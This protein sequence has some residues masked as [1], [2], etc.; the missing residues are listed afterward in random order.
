M[1]HGQAEMLGSID[2]QRSLTEHGKQEAY[3]MAQWLQQKQPSLSHVFVSPF[4]RAQQTA[5]VVLSE[6]KSTPNCQ[7]V[8]FITPEGSAKAFHDF[9]DGVCEVE[10]ISSLLVVSHMPLVSFLIEELTTEQQ[11]PI[12]QTAAIAQIDYDLKAMK[13]QL[14]NL[15]SPNELVKN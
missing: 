9:L 4:K 7:T 13:G 15:I 5:D 1:R 10:N 12:F 2:A 11:T 6:L 14:I 3:D 8:S